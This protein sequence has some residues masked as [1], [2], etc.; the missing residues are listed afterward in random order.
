MRS[1]FIPTVLLKVYVSPFIPS[2]SKWWRLL[3][4]PS[5]NLLPTGSRPWW[6]SITIQN[7]QGRAYLES[8]LV[9]F[10][11]RRNT[12]DSS[13]LIWQLGIRTSSSSICLLPKRVER[14]TMCLSKVPKSSNSRSSESSSVTFS[15]PSPTDS[16]G[17]D[18]SSASSI[19]TSLGEVN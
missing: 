9:C 10:S 16:K 17:D 5:I 19:S 12:L 14:T 7:K 4:S 15:F 13:R 6:L 2:S 11:K 8:H 18:Q 3:K 1:G